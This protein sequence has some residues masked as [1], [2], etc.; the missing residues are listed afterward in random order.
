MHAQFFIMHHRNIIKIKIKR[1][2]TKESILKHTDNNVSKAYIT[3]ATS[4]KTKPYLT[5]TTKMKTTVTLSTL[6]LTV[7]SSPGGAPICL[8]GKAAI[9]AIQGSAMGS[10]V[11]TTLAPDTFAF[12]VSPLAADGTVTI[13]QSGPAFN[14]LVMFCDA[15]GKKS[16]A[17]TVPADMQPAASCG[18][19][20]VGLTHTAGKTTGAGYDGNSKYTFKPS[21]PCTLGATVIQNVAGK[22]NL[23]SNDNIAK[24]DVVDPAATGQPATGQPGAGY[25]KVAGANASAPA[26]ACACMKTFKMCKVNQQV[27]GLKTGTYGSKTGTYGNK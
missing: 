11:G 10:M 16:G 4:Q 19:G 21:E 17:W 20:P 13:S 5:S 3:N 15:G 6:L 1:A 7:N 9:D 27:A 22:F 26:P 8:A 14:G 23:F 18:A 12:T 2:E 25:E 24:V